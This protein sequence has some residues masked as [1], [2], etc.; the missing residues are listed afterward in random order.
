MSERKPVHEMT[1]QELR[2]EVLTLRDLIDRPTRVSIDYATG[3]HFRAPTTAQVPDPSWSQPR[4]VCSG[5][6]WGEIR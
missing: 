4:T 6:P 5:M 1:L 2:D 3:P